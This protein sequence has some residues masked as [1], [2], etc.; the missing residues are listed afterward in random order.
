[1]ATYNSETIKTPLTIHSMM[2]RKIKSYPK[3]IGNQWVEDYV[4]YINNT[5]NKQIQKYHCFL[6]K[7]S[8]IMYDDS[9]ILRVVEA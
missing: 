1:M 8:R 4:V 9:R 3:K 6:D 7:N 2:G 5:H